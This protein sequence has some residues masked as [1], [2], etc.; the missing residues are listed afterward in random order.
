MQRPCPIPGCPELV[1]AGRCPTHAAHRRTLKTTTERGY[2]AAWKR[3]RLWFINHHP[4]CA[5]CGI[6]ATDEVHHVKKLV[7]FPEL[8][9]VESNCMGLCT[10][11]H[12]IRTQRGE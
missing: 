12:R 5:D 2:D 3:F 1:D 8:R 4:I 6:K 9:L 7:D 10:R 11:C